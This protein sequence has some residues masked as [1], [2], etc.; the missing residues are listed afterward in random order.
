MAD[1]TKKKKS[2]LESFFG[3]ADDGADLLGEATAKVKGM[4]GQDYASLSRLASEAKAF[5]K[6]VLG[7]T[8]SLNLDPVLEKAG[9]VAGGIKEL[10]PKKKKGSR[11]IL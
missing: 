2:F 6:K 3:M 11:W 7:S 4:A 5:G 1:P 10:V 8:P 9:E